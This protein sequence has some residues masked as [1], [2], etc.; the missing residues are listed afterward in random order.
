MQETFAEWLQQQRSLLHYSRMDLAESL[1]ISVDLIAELEANRFLPS[2][3]LAK[4]FFDLF[5]LSVEE[6]QLLFAKYAAH[7]SLPLEPQLPPLQ[8]GLFGQ[9][10]LLEQI[11]QALGHDCRVVSLLGMGGI[12][13][14]RIAIQAAYRLSPRFIDG[15][16]FIDLTQIADP[17]L[18]LVQL[19]HAFHLPDCLPQTVLEE[20]VALLHHKRVLLLI[21]SCE[22]V[23]PAM[24]DLEELLKRLPLLHILF[25]SRVRFHVQN[26]QSFLVGPLE[27]PSR[28]Q[29]YQRP[30]AYLEALATIASVALF[31][32]RARTSLPLFQLNERNADTVAQI[33]ILLEGVPLAIELAVSHLQILT[34]QGLLQRLENRL[35]ALKQQNAPSERH[36]S[37]R[38]SL[39]WSYALLPLSAQILLRRLALFQSGATLE[40]IEQLCAFA[41]LDRPDDSGID[42]MENLMILLDHQLVVRR[43]RNEYEID[44][45]MFEL[46]RLY[47]LERLEES[48]ERTL[49]YRRFARYYLAYIQTAIAHRSGSEG[50]LW[51]ERLDQH[52]P[53]I[54]LLLIWSLEERSDPALGLA[55][56]VAIWRY[57]D[58]RGLSDE[59]WKW[60]N[61]ALNLTPERVDLER[62]QALQ[63][64]G[65][66]SRTRWEPTITCDLLE[67]SLALFRRLDDLYG[68]VDVLTNL[69]TFSFDRGSYEEAEHYAEEVLPL[70]RQLDDSLLAAW[71]F[72]QMTRIAIWRNEF[73]WAL[74]VAQEALSLARSIRHKSAMAWSMYYTSR[75]MT[76]IFNYDSALLMAE[77]SV[78]LFRQIN[79]GYG[80]A[81]A[82]HLLAEIHQSMGDKARASLLLHESIELRANLE[83]RFHMARIC[84]TRG[85]LA[86]AE[87]N[88]SDAYTYYDDARRLFDLIGE[89]IEMS[90]ALFGL[91]RVGPSSQDVVTIRRLLDRFSKEMQRA[92][93]SA[94]AAW[95][96]SL[97]DAAL[98]L[99]NPEEAMV[100]LEQ[101]LAEARQ[102]GEVW[103]L[104]ASLQCYVSV[105]GQNR[106]RPYPHNLVRE[107]VQL[108]YDIG[109]HLSLL[110]HTVSLACF[111][112]HEDRFEDAAYLAGLSETLQERLGTGYCAVTLPQ[113]DSYQCSWIS[114]SIR[115]RF[116]ETNIAEAWARGR[117][118]TAEQGLHFVLG[119]LDRFSKA[120]NYLEEL[121]EVYD[122]S[123]PKSSINDLESFAYT[124]SHDLRA[125]LHA[126]DGYTQILIED[127]QGSLSEEA[128]QVYSIIR[129]ET[130]RMRELIDKLVSFA[131]FGHSSIHLEPIAMNAMVQAAFVD[132]TVDQDL[133][134]IHLEVEELPVALGDMVLVRQIWVNLLSNAIKYSSHRPNTH[135]S[136][137]AT[138]KL[139]TVTYKIEDNGTGFDMQQAHRLFGVFQ[140]LHTDNEF[141]GIGVGLAIVQRIVQRHGGRIWAEGR[142][143]QGASFF[144]TL[145]KS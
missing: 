92:K 106:T 111:A 66:I 31:V 88:Y 139:Y 119:F 98:A 123:L 63:A 61:T 23:V 26:E 59:G 34:P 42:V 97:R 95:G 109:D 22:R 112:W 65:W 57:W 71:A 94:W 84:L 69:M 117:H 48:G 11:C 132:V 5:A 47:A 91:S 27:L 16:F 43:E 129:N 86:E 145:P 17:S 62:A 144:F 115:S 46:V 25:T 50:P 100:L 142:P 99:H 76:R 108:A 96:R 118:S 40:L 29:E 18:V 137:S 9:T 51:M 78:M 53:N 21:D 72:I 45:A 87:Q 140:R 113:R 101:G 85:R 130:G 138:T 39:A 49:L 90:W 32:D 121:Q 38:L 58:W 28:Q 104:S 125:P 131:R 103:D 105:A 75:V 19:A 79:S 41:P 124:V 114:S 14:T 80:A 36:Q 141:A 133:S 83:D 120:W 60:L 3:Q 15:I 136:I 44:F 13:K 33:C 68:M 67:R 74:E 2:S 12:G 24:R 122:G 20:L 56:A 107:G 10:E 128:Q 35:E 77:E 143:D 54:R 73:N 127:L 4:R 55:L 64:A 6:Q 8:S 89:P 93:H 1:G 116:V 102:S 52:Y 135:I 30:E 110:V 37:L 7:L 81:I 126:I 134:R 70:V 82:L